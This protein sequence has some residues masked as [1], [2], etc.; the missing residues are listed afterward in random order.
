[1][2]LKFLTAY[3]TALT[4]KGYV[5]EQAILEKIASANVTHPGFPHITPLLFHFTVDSKYGQHAVM[6]TE[7]LGSD[8]HSLRVQRPNRRFS[9][10]ATKRIVKQILFA[11][12][13]IHTECGV[14]HT[15]KRS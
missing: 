1:M 4:S 9:L 2:A 7:A 8:L 6:C 3:Q 15:G 13:Y 10:L 11:L 5:A 14:I 12:D